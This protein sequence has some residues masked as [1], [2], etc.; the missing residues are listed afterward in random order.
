MWVLGDSFSTCTVSEINIYLI[1][2]YL[3]SFMSIFM[4][5][6]KYVHEI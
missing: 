5:C 1:L 6:L 3:L 4:Q 2:E